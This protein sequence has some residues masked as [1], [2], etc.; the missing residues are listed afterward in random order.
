MT[1]RT[2]NAQSRLVAVRWPHELYNRV[3]A[4]AKATNTKAS[5]VLIEAVRQG[6]P[7]P[8]KRDVPLSEALAELQEVMDNQREA[9]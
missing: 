4:V 8:L 9:K 5:Q 3:E 6:L 7:A 2:Q 1:P